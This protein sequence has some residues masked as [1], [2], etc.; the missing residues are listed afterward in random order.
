MEQELGEYCTWGLI[1]LQF[2][3]CV[4]ACVFLMILLINVESSPTQNQ[5]AE[6]GAVSPLSEHNN[7]R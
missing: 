5:S 7:C 2:F 1:L 6:T 4:R 3:L